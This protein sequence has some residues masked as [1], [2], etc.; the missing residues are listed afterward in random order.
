MRFFSLTNKFCNYTPKIYFFHIHVFAFAWTDLKRG[1]CFF[2]CVFSPV[3][4]CSA[5]NWVSL[6]SKIHI[7]STN[8]TLQYANTKIKRWLNFSQVQVYL[9]SNLMA[10]IMND[11]FAPFLQYSGLKPLKPSACWEKLL[12]WNE[13]VPANCKMLLCFAVRSCFMYLFKVTHGSLLWCDVVLYMDVLLSWMQACSHLSDIWVQIKS[14][15]LFH[16]SS[17]KFHVLIVLQ[18][19]SHGSDIQWWS[20]TH[21]KKVGTEACTINACQYKCWWLKWLC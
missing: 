18:A 4:L 20:A 15:V 13:W 1:C 16:K 8:N 17:L 5:S 9:F 19:F 7:R 2:F 21:S 12:F 3:S 14:E 6:L 10:C 11:C